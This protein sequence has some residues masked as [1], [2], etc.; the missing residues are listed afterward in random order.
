MLR[1]VINSTATVDFHLFLADPH[2]ILQ[3]FSQFGKFQILHIDE[4]MKP[5]S[6]YPSQCQWA[7]HAVLDPIHIGA[8]DLIPIFIAID[9][10][11]TRKLADIKINYSKLILICILF[12]KYA[13]SFEEIRCGSD[14]R[15]E[16]PFP[17]PPSDLPLRSAPPGTLYPAIGKYIVLLR[18]PHYKTVSEYVPAICKFSSI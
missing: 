3:Q 17:S 7:K 6:R 10:I 9:I 2:R 18:A 13:L 1:N 14:N 5:V 8:D 12:Q 4:C 16:D 11:Q 15:S